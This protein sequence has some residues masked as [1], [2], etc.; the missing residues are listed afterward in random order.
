MVS[1]E[2]RQTSKTAAT[3]VMLAAVA[4]SFSALSQP[5][6][7]LAATDAQRQTVEKIQEIQSRDGPNSADL[8]EPLTVLGLLYEE[9]EDHYLTSAAFERARQIVRVNYGFSSI[10]EVLLLWHLVRTEEARGSVE[11]AWDLEQELLKLVGR[12]PNDLRMV[13]ILREIADKRTDILERYLAG[14][15]PPQIVLGCYYHF[16]GKQNCHSGSRRNVISSLSMVVRRYRSDALR[17][18]RWAHGCERWPVPEIPHKKELS[19]PEER[20]IERDVR[21]YM[22]RMS[23]YVRC[24]Q[25]QY[26]TAA[27]TNAPASRLSPLDSENRVAVA[28]M[29]EVLATFKERVGS[30]Y[31]LEGYLP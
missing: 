28:E 5:E 19:R 11:V 29:E 3:M 14:E 1:L 17:I 12:H 2:I 24:L 6:F 27:N 22:W 21:L 4:V 16:F 18:E 9:D 8:I 7:D 26:E 13:P 20:L 31:F 15:F 30:T 25:A 10:E 23:D